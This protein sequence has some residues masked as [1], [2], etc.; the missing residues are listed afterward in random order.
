MR[1][2][3][4]Y[5]ETNELIARLNLPM[6]AIELPNKVFK[7]GKN[8]YGSPIHYEVSDFYYDVTIGGY[9]VKLSEFKFKNVIDLNSVSDYIME[10]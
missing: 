5:D 9:H 7:I 8:E 4:Y 1:L 6:K 2:H 3:L 10:V